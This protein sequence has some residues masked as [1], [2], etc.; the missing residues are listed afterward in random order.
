MPGKVSAAPPA[1]AMSACCVCSAAAAWATAE[2]AE[3][4]AELTESDGP[5]RSSAYETRVAM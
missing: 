2:S 1:S 4:H 5:I 3:E